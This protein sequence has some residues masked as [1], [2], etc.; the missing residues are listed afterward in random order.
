MA[1]RNILFFTGL[2]VLCL[3]ASSPAQAREKAIFISIIDGDSMKVEIQGRT[4]E[5]RLIGIDAPEW[6]QE[7]GTKAKTFALKFCHG[8]PLSLEY[9]VKQKDRFGRHLAYVYVG[10][11]MLNEELVLNGLALSVKYN[12]NTRHQARLNQAQQVAQKSRQGFWLHGG[13]KKTPR[14]WRKKY[15]E[16]MQQ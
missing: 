14:E 4:R 6:G 12:P 1:L 11:K 10:Q 13:L 2:F 8:R 9:D 5:V 16:K 15:R 3:L 7:Y